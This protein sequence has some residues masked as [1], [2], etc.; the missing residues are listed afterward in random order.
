M[1]T[2]ASKESGNKI[3]Y[4][5]MLPEGCLADTLAHTTPTDACR[6]AL[7]APAF[8]SIADSN[9]VWERFLP[10]DYSQLISRAVPAHRHILDHLALSPKKKLYL[11]L[12]DNPLVID[13][14]T[15]SFSLDKWTG[16]KCFMIA[17]R[18]L[19]I[20]WGDTPRYWRWTFDKESRF[21]KAIELISVCW[22]EIHGRINTSLLSPDTDY[23][24]YLVYKPSIAVYGFEHQPVEIWI[25]LS[26]EECVKCTFI[27][28]P[29]GG[30]QANYVRMPPP[31]RLSLL[32]SN[33]ANQPRPQ[34]PIPVGIETRCPRVRKDGWL[35][36]D[37][38]QYFHKEGEN[39]ELEITMME[40]KGGHWKSG[41]IIQGIEIRAKSGN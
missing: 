3:D 17:A 22:L 34:V 13:N 2:Q 28:D 4:F 18:E 35:E 5:D 30:L 16:K 1:A 21:G 12:C 8:R 23:T 39:R 19:A 14:G 25:G 15:L 7:V 26:G 32:H 6:L 41:L 31:R 33:R 38:A 10:C 9:G 37:L 36:I 20:V 11:F 27:L 24:A 40:T 29:E